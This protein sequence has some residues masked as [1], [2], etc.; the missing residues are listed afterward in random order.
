MF[1]YLLLLTTIY[2]VSCQTQPHY[3][4]G[5]FNYPDHVADSDTILY[6]YQLKDFQ[7]ERDN[8][9][10]RYYYLFYRA[11]NEPNLSLRPQPKETFR[12]TYQTAFGDAVIVAFNEDSLI[13][14]K[15]NPA[16]LYDEDT[17]RLST[18]EKLH[19]K[20]LDKRFPV[21]TEN[22][23]PHVKRYLDSMV[24]LY[25]QLLDPAYYHQLYNKRLV[26]TGEQFS[27]L[28]NEIPLTKKQYR[29][30]VQ[31]I[32]ASGFWSMPYETKCKE[33][34][35]DGYGFTLEANTST[36][37]KVVNVQGCPNDTSGFTKACQRII[38][39]SKLNKKINLVWR[40]GYY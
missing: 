38:E 24:R 13:V 39:L 1:K 17:T 9:R 26:S 19:V 2:F 37:Y 4:D 30:L 6:Y 10:A 22:S 35:T 25:P 16:N 20:I 33:S 23:R 14:K 3:P 5:G 32:N 12:L 11:F 8:F 40:D 7:S 28:V 21:D 15:G 34:S 18:I 31:E 27:P 29:S 36:K